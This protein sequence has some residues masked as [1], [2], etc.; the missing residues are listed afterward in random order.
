M[1]RS[2]HL[3]RSV[4]AARSHIYGTLNPIGSLYT[5]G[6]LLLCD[7]LAHQEALDSLGSDRSSDPPFAH[8]RASRSLARQCDI[9][10]QS[11]KRGRQKMLA[12][13]RTPDDHSPATGRRL[14]SLDCRRSH[15][16]CRAIDVTDSGTI[17]DTRA[18]RRSMRSTAP[19]PKTAR[20][21]F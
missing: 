19:W 8:S 13:S 4:R 17:I 18:L 12:K 15:P 14:Q 3:V 7:S 21:A 10:R 20:P 1:A 5:L 9:Q 6:A 11:K 16:D 2:S